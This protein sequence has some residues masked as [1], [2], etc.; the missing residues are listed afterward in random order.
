MELP[1]V[2][3]ISD[4]PETINYMKPS[5]R[6][7]GGH[8]GGGIELLMNDKVK[9]GQSS[10][11]HSGNADISDLSKLEFE[12]N[13]LS[14]IGSHQGSRMDSGFGTESKNSHKST[15]FELPSFTEDIPTI[16]INNTLGESTADSRC[17]QRQKHRSSKLP[18]W[19]SCQPTY[20]Y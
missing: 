19:P 12:L 1:S 2:I 4:I 18:S 15:S 20:F 3:E 11:S 17:H 13:E 6:N 10:H 8:F 7:M 14:N 9:T 5:Q 16:N